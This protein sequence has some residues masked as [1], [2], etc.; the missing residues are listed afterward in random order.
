MES[1]GGSW[2]LWLCHCGLLYLF[3]A[4]PHLAPTPRGTIEISSA[5]G[6][7]RCPP[8]PEV[9]DPERASVIRAVF[10]QRAEGL[11]IMGS[12]VFGARQEF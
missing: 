7:R 12:V 8:L 11:G 4:G 6:S 2:R 1:V 3:K 5:D 9:T 10:S